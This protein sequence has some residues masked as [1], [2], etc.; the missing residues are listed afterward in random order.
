MAVAP[1]PHAAR[2]GLAAL[3]VNLLAVVPLAK[4]ETAYRPDLLD[5]W[6]YALGEH[7]LA[8]GWS[9]WLLAGGSL[10]LVPWLLGLAQ[11]LGPAGR[12]GASVAVAA[13]VVRAGASLL[14]FVAAHYVPHGNDAIVT[15][16]LGTTLVFEG[17]FHLGFGLGLAQMAIA[18]AANRRH[19]LWL[20]GLGM[21]AGLMTFPVVATAWSPA[22]ATFAPVAMMGW[23]FWLGLTSLHLFR[24]WDAADVRA[25]RSRA[26]TRVPL[27]APAE[28][29]PPVRAP[30]PSSG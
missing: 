22:A 23:S 9:A 28:T 11:A 4:V 19:P 2:M 14:P 26:Q 8:V 17:L 13:A 12:T 24:P 18:M 21:V 10:L 29:P 15:V 7:E 25:G 6:A 20:S 1:D 16:L 3:A 30:Q 5:R 27:A